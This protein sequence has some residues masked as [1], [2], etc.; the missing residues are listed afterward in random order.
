[1]CI[2]FNG[3]VEMNDVIAAISTPY[4]RGGIAVLRISGEGAIECADRMFCPASG[5]PLADTEGGRVVYGR[6]LHSGE[7]IDDGC[8]AVFRAPRSF[9]GEDTVEISCHGGILIAQKVL[10]SILISGARPAEGGEFSRRAFISGKITLTEAEAIMDII[11]AESDDALKIAASQGEGVLS[12][13]IDLLRERLVALLSQV[14]VYIDYPDEDLTDVTAAEA[15]DILR[16]IRDKAE[17]LL[18]TYSTGRTVSRGINAVICGKPNTGKSSLLNRILGRERAIVTDIA[19]TTRDTIEENATLGRVPLHLVDTAGLHETSDTVEALGVERSRRSLDDAELVLAVFDASSP[20]SDEDRN[21]ISL[22]RGEKS[23]ETLIL[24][25]KTDRDCL[26]TE[27]DFPGFKDIL[28]VS[29]LTGEG[30]E[31]LVRTVNDRFIDGKIDLR[32][33][34]VISNARQY[35]ALKKAAD[36]LDGALACLERGQ[37]PDVAG[38]DIEAAIG[39]LGELDGRSVGEEIVQGIFSRFCVG[40]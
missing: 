14:Y 39:A 1:M 3:G 26:L 13:Q 9:T 4:G 19:G 32:H 11:D 7:R 35:A 30:F 6:I 22:L 5:R 37:S 36:A 15:A 24:L 12:S 33:D 10:E 16:G 38:L 18:A 31:A 2:L 25:N 28:K 34:A 20:L 17:A 8:A 40:K 21:V 29:C 27:D 23:A